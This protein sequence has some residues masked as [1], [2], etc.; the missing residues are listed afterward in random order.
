MKRLAIIDLYKWKENKRHKPLI[1]KGARQVGKTWLIKEFAKEAYEKSVYI[2]FEEDEMLQNVF[3]KDFDTKRIITTISLA[4]DIDIDSETLL[5][6]DEIQAAPRGITSLKYF[7]ENAPEYDIICAG[8]LL[9]IAMHNND[10][11][12]VGKVNFIDVSPM[13]FEEFL[14][15]VAGKKYVDLIKSGD[16]ELIHTIKDKLISW[17]K[18]Y[19]VVG[20]M[21]EV[22]DTYCK[23]NDFS[24]VRTV[25]DDIL[26]TYSNDFSKHAPINEVPRIRMVWNSI[27]GQLAK[28]NRKFLYGMLKDG[29]RAKEFELAIEWLIDAGLVS[30]VNRTK[31]GEFPL[32][33]YE[34]FSAF[35]LYMI[36][37]GLM[38]AMSKISANVIINGNELF[39]T[40]KGAL[41]EQYVYQQLKPSADSIFYWSAENSRGELDFIMQSDNKILPIEVKA[42]E[43]LKAKSLKFFVDKFKGL[44]GIRISMADYRRQ[45]WL[46]NIPLYTLSMHN[47]SEE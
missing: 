32:N 33:A 40:F 42:E 36:D 19:Y 38:C 46:T 39:S 13:N 47:I 4:K 34:D 10:S 25:Q 8:S 17:L 3:L 29:G 24:D 37:I 27:L 30:K 14:L 28:E 31:S 43:N 44:H 22:V 6:F 26:E 20:G 1:I 9:G 45:D 35:K 18:T 16:W 21:P 11:F 12:P 2:N 15:A 23:T 41:T 5:I 7:C